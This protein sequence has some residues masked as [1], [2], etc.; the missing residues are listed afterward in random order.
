MKDFSF[1]G[2]VYV[3]TRLAGGIAGALRWV[4]DAPKCDVSLTTESEN[5]KESYSG[6]R[7]TSARLRKGNEATIAMTLNW[8]DADNL[9]LGLYGTTAAVAAGTV[10]AETLPTGLAAGDVV[11]LDHGGVSSLVI[12]DSAGTPATLVAGTDY[13]LDS[14]NGGVVSIKNVGSYVQP[15]KAAY[16]HT[17]S[18]DVS[19]FTAAP[20]E[21]Y[22]LLDGVNT[23]DDSPV[24]LRLYR[25]QFDPAATLPLINEGFGSIELSGAVLYDSEA[26]A[27]ATLG[28]FGKIELPTAV[29]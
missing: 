12:T 27:D 9:A 21:R 26:A 23:V 14:A 28:G 15:F 17:A 24:R 4:G 3:G 1:Q 18:S 10:T 8:A 5:R 6:Q 20:P 22:L 19:M 25:V 13:A 16:S 2:K 29:A 11:V 7:L